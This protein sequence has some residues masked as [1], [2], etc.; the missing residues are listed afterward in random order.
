[1][2]K[3]LK[4]IVV[5]ASLMAISSGAKAALI[6]QDFAVAG[7]GLLILDTV[8]NRQWVDVSHTT[9][10]GGVN[11]FF[12][13]SMFAGKG[14]Q[15]AK[16]ADV[17]QFFTDAGAGNV[18]NGDNGSFTSNNYAAA[19]S[20]YSLMEHTAPFSNMGFNPWIH[21]FYYYNDTLATIGRIGN[22]DFLGQSGRAS[23]DVG[24]NGVWGLNDNVGQQVG[25]WAFRT[26][27]V[28]EPGSVALLGFGIAALGLS[29]RRNKA[30]K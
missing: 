4:L 7:D 25:I 17:A 11:G 15:L 24:S 26:A 27:E 29:R 19:T 30:A 16:A 14:F 18:L 21:G 12:A 20:I 23:F 2:K 22:G 6:E 10:T 13:T 28:P 8:T 9:N 1:M 3:F 5:A